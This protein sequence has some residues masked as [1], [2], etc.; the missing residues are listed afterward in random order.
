MKKIIVL[1]TVVCAIFP[2]LT[3][4]G[5][6][7]KD[8]ATQIKQIKFKPG[9]H[10]QTTKIVILHPM[11]KDK[12]TELVHTSSL[13]WGK[14]KCTKKVEDFQ[15]TK[16]KPVK[17]ETGVGQSFPYNYP[18]IDLL[19][20]CEKSEISN[21]K[22]ASEGLT[23]DGQKLKGYKFLVLDD[24]KS[25]LC[26]LF[27]NDKDEICALSMGFDRNGIKSDANMKES[28]KTWYFK[29]IDGLL[30]LVKESIVT[31]EKKSGIPILK[32]ELIEFK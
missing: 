1:V 26:S 3:A 20:F 11:V 19:K 18:P 10:L 7:F 22:I 31:A 24:G 23:L 32:T 15:Q 6:E 28:G 5:I 25:K 21:W 30:A 2:F 29:K 17:G 16:G 4:E 13:N 14:G 27:L 12:I 9:T 8:F